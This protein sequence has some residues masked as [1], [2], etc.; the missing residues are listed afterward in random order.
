MASLFGLAA[1]GV[2]TTLD[3]NL[4]LVTSLAVERDGRIAAPLH[5]APWADEADP[6]AE[7][8]GAA[9]HLA[10][11]AGDFFCAP[12]G[13]ADIEDAPTHGW[14]ANS[15]WL[16]VASE[17]LGDGVRATFRLLKPVLGATLY[18]QLTLR[19]GH[20]FLYQR[21]V[22]E[23]GSG[24]VSVA[25]HPMVRLPNGGRLSYS[26]K[27]WAET[28]DT[29]LEPDPTRGRAAL[30]YPA[31]TTDLRHFPTA[32]GGSV[33]LTSFP[34]AESHEDFVMLVEP[35]GAELGWTAVLRPGEGDLSLVLKNPADLPVTMLWFS[36]G[37]RFFAP[38]NGRHRDVIGVEDARAFS[39]YGHAASA[40]PN[41]LSEAGIAT[42][43]QLD[44]AGSAEVRHVLGVLPVPPGFAAAAS[45]DAQP[46][47]LEIADA[48]GVKLSLPYDAGF[49][50]GP[51]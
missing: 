10:R 19:D 1:Q 24:S 16:P 26:P 38:W 45:I 49:L 40:A 3:L 34:I 46:G 25:H 4:G 32:D 36:N 12:F 20:P 44:P 30:A 17:S 50:A 9:P 28:P 37:G 42:A 29:P 48:A 39:A 11:L 8:P 5:R 51:R 33:D 7:A 22:F 14:P 31:Q 47:K 15:A 35:E 2:S 43:L 27:R 13:K 18:K 41:R 21:H 6:V 23:G